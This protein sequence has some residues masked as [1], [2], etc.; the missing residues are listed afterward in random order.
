MAETPKKKRPHSL[1]DH[2]LGIDPTHTHEDGEADHDHDH[3]DWAAS[4][5]RRPPASGCRTT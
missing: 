3:D 2:L 4:T 5:I 1:E